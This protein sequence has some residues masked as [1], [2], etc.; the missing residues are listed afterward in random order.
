MTSATDKDGNVTFNITT[1]LNEN[2]V[3][4]ATATADGKDTSDQ[5]S[6]I[7]TV[8]TPNPNPTPTPT[9]APTPT[10]PPAPNPTPAPTPAGR[11]CQDDGYPAGYYWSD[12]EQACIIDYVPTP[13]PKPVIANKPVVKPTPIPTATPAPTQSATPT[14]TPTPTATPSAKPQL[15]KEEQCKLDG[16]YWYDNDCH[17]EA[18]VEGSWALVNL[19]LTIVSLIMGIILILLK[20]EKEEDGVVYVRNKVYKLLI[21]LPVLIS[22]ILFILTQDLSLPMAMIDKWTL[23]TFILTVISAIFAIFGSRFKEKEEE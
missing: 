9:D 10:T 13:T 18:K 23:I 20:T 11:T 3:V 4:T 5:V 22:A 16:K 1:P 2:D 15:S 12:A 17:L 8:D 14:P 21:V 6:T 19:I 7:V